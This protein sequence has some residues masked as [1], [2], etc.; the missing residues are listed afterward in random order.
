[1]SKSSSSFLGNFTK[2]QSLKMFEAYLLE[3]ATYAIA[4]AES[5]NA[6]NKHIN[7][8]ISSNTSRCVEAGTGTNEA[9]VAF[10]WCF[11]IISH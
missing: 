2:Y 4:N 11:S 1:M 6:T 8:F 9:D 10:I 3:I 7:R 5:A